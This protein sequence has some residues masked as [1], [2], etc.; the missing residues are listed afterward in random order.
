VEDAF[1]SRL[2]RW[3]ADARVADAAGQRSRERWLRE[4]AAQEAT[5]AGVLLDLGERRTTV[6]LDTAA[7]RSHRGI[8]VCVGADFVALQLSSGAEVL[9]ALSAIAA[10][11]LVAG[12]DL[13][14]G[15]RADATGL[16]LVEVLSTMAAERTRVLLVTRGEPV[17]GELRSAGLDVVTVRTDADPSAFAY[18]PLGGVL[19][20]L[21]A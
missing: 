20:V 5:L 16:T 2:E 19:E 13:A 7:G 9:V 21:V 4:V 6:A 11:R 3:A 17:S 10:V 14:T 18:V 15:D 8:V 1:G 12:E